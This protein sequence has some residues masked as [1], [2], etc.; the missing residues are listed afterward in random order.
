[1]P[2]VG[3]WLATGENEQFQVSVKV[4]HIDD[5]G[6][7]WPLVAPGEPTDDDSDAHDETEADV[8]AAACDVWMQFVADLVAVQTEIINAVLS[9]KVTK[10]CTDIFLK[11]Y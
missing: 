6:K 3:K 5:F 4:G 11:H 9:N 8:L 1:M 2:F 7:S 10:L